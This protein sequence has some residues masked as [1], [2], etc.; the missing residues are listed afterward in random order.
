[1][2]VRI[3]VIFAVSFCVRMRGTNIDFA[4]HVRWIEDA[5]MKAVELAPPSLTVSIRIFV[6]GRLKTAE[7]EPLLS[8]S[9]EKK[10]AE[11]IVTQSVSFSSLSLPP[12]DVRMENGRPNMGTLLKEEASM[13]SGRMSFAGRKAFHY[14]RWRAQRDSARR[15]IRLCLV[16]S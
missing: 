6:T 11:H 8:N 7:S 13:T 10:G 9:V 12:H 15:I 16:P 3:S 5:L 2:L 4:A 1:M 14:L